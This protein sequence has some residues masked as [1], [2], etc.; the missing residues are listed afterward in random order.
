MKAM[1]K[2]IICLVLAV[3]MA[4]LVSG[5]AEDLQ[6]LDIPP[7][8]EVTPT[9]VP[10]S[11]TQESILEMIEAQAA[12]G[13]Q[14][15]QPGETSS[16]VITEPEDH[17]RVLVTIGNTTLQSYDPAEGTELILTFSYDMPRVYDEAS[18]DAAARI[19]ETLA[20]VEEIFYTGNSY[21]MEGDYS[22]YSAMLT[23]AEDNFTYVYE[24]GAPMSTVLT[25][26]S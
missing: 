7:F 3:V 2:K 17:I 23:A 22:G 15:A 13:A 24:T 19:N 4:L 25:T 12:E 21:G 6:D 18:P 10:V 20:T 26:G 9:P 5:C 14:D 16:V 11:P 8:P 1:K